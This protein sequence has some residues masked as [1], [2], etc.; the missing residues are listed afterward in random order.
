MMVNARRSE[1]T[2]RVSVLGF[3]VQVCG[4]DPPF[5]DGGVGTAAG[6]VGTVMC[7][8]MLCAAAGGALAKAGSH[9]VITP[10]NSLSQKA[11]VV[12]PSA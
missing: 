6:S 7:S 1:A 4:F 2:I 5:R 10:I 8:R 12:P 11:T 3:R 9:D